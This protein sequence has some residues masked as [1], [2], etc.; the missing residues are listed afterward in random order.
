MKITCPQCDNVGKAKAKVEVGAKVKC[1]HC[2]AVFAYAPPT[3]VPAEQPIELVSAATPVGMSDAQAKSLDKS[4][5]L[6]LV[7]LVI[8][9]LIAMSIR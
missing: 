8:A 1:S 5:R 3:F 7:M 6:F 9:I 4:S 2:G